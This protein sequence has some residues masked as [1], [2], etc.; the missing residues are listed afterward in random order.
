[1]K[2]SNNG[3]IE[4]RL[5][6]RG[7]DG[8]VARV[9]LLE[10]QDGGSFKPVEGDFTQEHA[11]HTRLFAKAASTV[12]KGVV[13][14][15]DIDAIVADVNVPTRGKKRTGRKSVGLRDERPKI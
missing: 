8:K 9:R 14:P 15:L 4:Y 2:T 1:M 13:P 6:L 3:K 10:R 12:A 5:D 11:L 7:S